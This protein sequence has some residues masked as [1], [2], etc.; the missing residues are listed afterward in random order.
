MIASTKRLYKSR[1]E[2]SLSGL[3]GGIAEFFGIDPTIVRLITVILALMG[4]WVIIMYLIGWLI[5]PIEPE[6]TNSDKEKE[7][8]I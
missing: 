6:P 3:C 4:G 7:A 2:K 8:Q 5:V 1:K